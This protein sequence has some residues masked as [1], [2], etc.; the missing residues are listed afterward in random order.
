MLPLDNWNILT[1]KLVC[2][3]LILMSKVL[4]NEIGISIILYKYKRSDAKDKCSNA[5][6][7][8]ELLQ[9]LGQLETHRH[10]YPIQGNIFIIEV[11][12]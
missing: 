4:Q 9:A 2:V 10:W 1:T 12:V 3:S 6:G 5:K 8:F 7:S 11:F